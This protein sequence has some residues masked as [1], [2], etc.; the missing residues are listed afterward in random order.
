MQRPAKSVEYLRHV[1]T[2]DERLKMGEQLAQCYNT[3]AAISDEEKVMKSKFAERKTTTEQ[4]VRSL[5]QDLATGWTMTN[6]PCLLKWGSPN[7]NEVEYVREDTN[8]VIRT[9]AMTPEELQ[10]D[11]PFNEQVKA[12]SE[13]QASALR[14]AE[15]IEGF[16][17]CKDSGGEEQEETDPDQEPDE[18]DED[19]EE[20]EFATA[21]AP[22]QK[23]GP[24]DLKAFHEKEVEK[25]S[26]RGRKKVTS[27]PF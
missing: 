11:L 15:N 2:Q 21:A 20:A 17:K 24:S 16:F 27:E 12:D 19:E 23:S 9:R 6:V 5:S 25:E 14:S 18:G 1:F 3:L 13:A 22:A 4:S 7:A 26:K 10:E 8:E